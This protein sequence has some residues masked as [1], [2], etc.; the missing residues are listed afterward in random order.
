MDTP[1]RRFLI[2]GLSTAALSAGTWAWLRSNQYTVLPPLRVSDSESRPEVVA[3]PGA[4]YPPRALASL[5][6]L[7]DVLLPGA[8]HLSLPS[9]S[10][11]GVVE[12]LVAA[13][14]QPGLGPVRNDIL[15]LTRYLDRGAQSERGVRFSELADPALQALLVKEA[16]DNP[17]K[18]GR[19]VPALAVEATLRLSLEGYLGHPHYGGNQDFAVWQSLQIN[20]PR[21]RQPHHHKG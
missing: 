21:D 16:A 20:M 12:F 8:A 10:A 15:K 11:S 9:A 2:A 1:R 7:V 4:P 19:F 3:L 17:K 14:R 13:S 18:I 6:A 5:P